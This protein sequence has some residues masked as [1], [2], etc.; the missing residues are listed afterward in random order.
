MINTAQTCRSATGTWEQFAPIAYTATAA[1]RSRSMPTANRYGD[2]FDLD[3][4]TF[5]AVPYRAEPGA[6][7][8]LFLVEQ[9]RW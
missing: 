9:T 2:S 8:G 1:T 6:A 7:G 5:T 3:G 4:V